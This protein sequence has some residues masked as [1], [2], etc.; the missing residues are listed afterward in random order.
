MVL[1]AECC[2]WGFWRWCIVSFRSCGGG[3]GWMWV[4]VVN[5]SV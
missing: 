1:S 3:G 2:R 5:V 4:D